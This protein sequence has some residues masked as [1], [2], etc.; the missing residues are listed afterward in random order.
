MQAS[1][2]CLLVGRWY[3]IVCCCV[4]DGVKHKNRGTGCFGKGRSD[5]REAP[6][7]ALVISRCG[8]ESLTVWLRAI[9]REKLGLAKGISAPR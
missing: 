6:K 7:Y 4:F 5:H 8:P 2:G 3:G 1:S 9:C